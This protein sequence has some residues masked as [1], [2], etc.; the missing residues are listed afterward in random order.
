MGKILTLEHAIKISQKLRE[1]KKSVVLVGGVFDILHIGHVRFLREAKKT[2]DFLFL[3]L[4]SDQSVTKLKGKNRPF[5]KQGDRAQVLAALETVD[6][7]ILLSGILK[8]KDYD[9][10]VAQIQ[11]AIIAT[12]KSDAKNIN[13]ERQ[14]KNIGAKVLYVERIRNKSTSTILNKL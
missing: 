9:R 7:V 6:Y 3:L 4:E 11:P 8:N 5:N 1:Q 10:I 2:S 14:A 12:T 13:M